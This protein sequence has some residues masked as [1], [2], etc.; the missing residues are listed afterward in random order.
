M[1]NLFI[2]YPKCSTCQKAKKWLDENNIEY[3]DRN[4]ITETPSIE[5]LKEW[6]K[7]SGIDVKK[8]FNTSG[9]KYRELNIKEKIKEMSEDE[10]YKL[11]A[12]DGMLIK[13]PLFISGKKIL[14]GFKEKDWEE[15]KGENNAIN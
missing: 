7:R 4:I 13:R 6:I 1:K 3:I 8:F 14:K 2:E 11:L 9:I 5:E 15:I 10:I 12:S